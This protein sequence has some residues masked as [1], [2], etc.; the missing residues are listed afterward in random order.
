MNNDL[1]RR[2]LAEQQSKL[3]EERQWWDKKKASIQEGFMKELN[4]QGPASDSGSALAPKTTASK[5]SEAVSAAP[6]TSVQGSDDDAVLVEPETSGNTP[7]GGGGGKKKKG[8][9]K[10]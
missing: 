2:R 5:G 8:K 4:E 9:G 7:T 10:K 3:A 6:A 1:Y